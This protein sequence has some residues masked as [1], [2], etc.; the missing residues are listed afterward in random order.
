MAP[1]VFLIT[2]TS[3][4]FGNELAKT[5]LQH[6]DYL[7]ATARDS[8]K[9][10]FTGAN[11]S[12][13]LLVALDVTDLKSID[14]A[15]A[16]ALEKFGRL[17]VVVNN[18][19]FGLGGEFESL[20]ESEIR[21]QMDV[22]FFGVLNVTKKAMEAMREQN[23]SG[24]VIQQITSIGGQIGVP[25]CSICASPRLSAAFC[26]LILPPTRQRVKVGSRRLHGGSRR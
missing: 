9:L 14:N 26:K 7:V 10:R 24:G 17:D 2:G 16:K 3:T 12:N 20:S 1:R 15:F 6:G 4:G 5:V 11:E 8:S 13:S 25:L 18:A 22:N 21:M 23:P 19:G